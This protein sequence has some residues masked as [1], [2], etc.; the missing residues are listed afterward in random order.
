MKSIFIFFFYIILFTGPL[1]ASVIFP[2]KKY[3]VSDGLSH[4]TVWSILQDSYGFIWIGTSN[5]LNRYDGY[6]SRTYRHVEGVSRSLGNNF[7]SSLMEDNQDIWI[8]TNNGVY[9]YHRST[10]DFS[11][12]R[13][14]NTIRCI[15]Q[16]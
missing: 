2:F 16:L 7:I 6:T 15:C 10:D 11:F 5:G 12:F 9:I 8:G 13:Q 14:E 4:N 1:S 3:Q